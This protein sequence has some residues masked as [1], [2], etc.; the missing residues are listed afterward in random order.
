MIPAKKKKDPS[1][2]KK[3]SETEAAAAPVEDV[4]GDGATDEPSS[5]RPVPDGPEPKSKYSRFN[6]PPPPE[7]ANPL[8]AGSRNRVE[9]DDSAP[10]VVCMLPPL[11]AK[12]SR[13][14]SYTACVISEAVTGAFKTYQRNGMP[15]NLAYPR[16]QCVD[17]ANTFSGHA[18]KFTH[19]GYSTH[20]TDKIGRDVGRW[21]RILAPTPTAKAV[22]SGVY[23]NP[24]S[25]A[26]VAEHKDRAASDIGGGIEIA[27]A[28]GVSSAHALF[29]THAFADVVK[30]AIEDKQFGPPTEVCG[31]LVKRQKLVGCNPTTPADEHTHVLG[32]YV[33]VVNA[34]ASTTMGVKLTNISSTGTNGPLIFDLAHAV[35]PKYTREISIWRSDAKAIFGEPELA[36]TATS[37]LLVNGEPN[38]D[39]STAQFMVKAGYMLVD[40]SKTVSVASDLLKSVFNDCVYDPELDPYSKSIKAVLAGG[41]IVPLVAI[42]ATEDDTVLLNKKSLLTAIRNSAASG[43]STDDDGVLE[44]ARLVAESTADQLIAAIDDMDTE[45]SKHDS[46]EEVVDAIVKELE[47]DDDDN[48]KKRVLA[49]AHA[50]QFFS[51]STLAD[52]LPAVKGPTHETAEDDEEEEPS[53]ENCC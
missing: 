16:I 17:G 3:E 1:K 22:G 36:K 11:I 38:Q 25:N 46:I 39:P 52:L 29:N 48:A 23:V 30:K 28:A 12:T 24:E 14:T 9:S 20:P 32:R 51:R 27:I 5:K 6:R 26:V 21:G 10:M 40:E 41:G 19:I 18:A 53:Y 13:P 7:V 45:A 15:Y 34:P 31:T 50:F 8:S 42:R 4:Q 49:V 37:I 35:S 43:S 47:E 33:L 44:I 2:K